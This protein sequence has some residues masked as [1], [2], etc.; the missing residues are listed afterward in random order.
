MVCHS[1][2]SDSAEAVSGRLEGRLAQAPDAGCHQPGQQVC[3][4]LAAQREGD[5]LPGG[6]AYGCRNH[7][8]QRGQRDI[9][10]KKGVEADVGKVA[11]R[12]HLGRPAQKA[13]RVS[14]MAPKRGGSPPRSR[15]QNCSRSV[16]IC[17]GRVT[18]G[19]RMPSVCVGRAASCASLGGAQPCLVSVQQVGLVGVEVVPADDGVGRLHGQRVG[20]ATA[21][22]R[23]RLGAQQ[24]DGEVGQNGLTEPV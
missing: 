24:P 21:A 12:E 18:P 8:K 13:S 7:V 22:G 16:R 3:R 10:A 11:K 2:S 1:R 9:G 14:S 23:Q 5:A 20:R 15:E 17:S 6:L 4:G 19:S